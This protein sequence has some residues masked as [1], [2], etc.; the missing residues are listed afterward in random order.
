MGHDHVWDRGSSG[1][2]VWDRLWEALYESQGEW[3]AYIY[4]VDP[5]GRLVRPYLRKCAAWES[6]PDMLRDELGGGDFVVMIRSG[7]KMRF[8]GRVAVVEGFG[9]QRRNL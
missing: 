2:D 6:L 9:P 4:R 5:E 1:F 3:I 8:S 7:R